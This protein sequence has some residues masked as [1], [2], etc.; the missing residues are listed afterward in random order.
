ML[1]PYTPQNLGV[2]PAYSDRIVI[3]PTNRR[4]ELLPESK[5]LGDYCGKHGIP[6]RPAAP[7][8]REAKMFTLKNG[9]G[10]TIG[11]IEAILRE[12]EQ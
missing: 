8:T 7:G 9:E 2:K 3:L 10:R 11:G 1:S 12:L 5:R 4:G 6:T